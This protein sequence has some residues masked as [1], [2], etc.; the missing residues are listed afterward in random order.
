[1]FP[2]ERQ[3]E[4]SEVVPNEESSLFRFENKSLWKHHDDRS[5]V[6][7]RERPHHR[8]QWQERQVRHR[9]RFQHLEQPVDFERVVEGIAVSF[10]F[11]AIYLPMNIAVAGKP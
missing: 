7:H 10:K 11:I 3:K 4:N 2:A 1:M 8:L 9:I 5:R 6:R